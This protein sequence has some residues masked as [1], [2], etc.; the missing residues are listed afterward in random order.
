MGYGIFKKVRR[1]I[2]CKADVDK[3]GLNRKMCPKPE[4]I[5][6]YRNGLFCIIP[7]QIVQNALDNLDMYQKLSGKSI[8][9]SVYVTW[10]QG[11]SVDPKVGYALLG[12]Q[13][14]NQS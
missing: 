12:E 14:D 7:I 2:L 11:I 8:N 5:L 1:M 13:S 6:W 9:P 10:D 4:P 3:L